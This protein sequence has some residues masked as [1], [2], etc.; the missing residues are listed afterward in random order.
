MSWFWIALTGLVGIGVGA[1]L[2][3]WWAIKLA[4][5]VLISENRNRASDRTL[6]LSVL[7]RELA[8]WMFRHDPDRY[9][10][11]YVVAHEAVLA[12]AMMDRCKQEQKINEIA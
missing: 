12:I 1:F 3:L 5:P 6:A 10:N 4:Q 11:A 9:R 7:R 2:G 8:N